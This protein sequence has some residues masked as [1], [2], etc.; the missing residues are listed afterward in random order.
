MATITFKIMHYQDY[1]EVII[2]V[3]GYKRM[4]T[5]YHKGTSEDELIMLTAAD[6]Y[7]YKVEKIEDETE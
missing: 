2:S 1:D 5:R 6:W 3:D 4:S 7:G